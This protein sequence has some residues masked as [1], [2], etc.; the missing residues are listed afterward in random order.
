[1]AAHPAVM[2]YPTQEEELRAKEAA[3]EDA[4]NAEESRFLSTFQ[5]VPKSNG[6]QLVRLANV[7]VTNFNNIM[8]ESRQ[9]PFQRQE[10]VMAGMKKLFQEQINVIEARRQYA[11]KLNPST[12]AKQD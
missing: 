6:E 8:S 3:A 4:K 12:A 10:D 2:S 1:M 9:R 5:G 7:I 11:T